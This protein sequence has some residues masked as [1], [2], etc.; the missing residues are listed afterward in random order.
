[1][2]TSVVQSPP[3][4]CICQYFSYCRLCQTCSA[5]EFVVTDTVCYRES[6]E[7]AIDWDLF[8]SW[9]ALQKTYWAHAAWV[10]G[11]CWLLVSLPCWEVHIW[12]RTDICRY[13]YTLASLPLTGDSMIWD[14]PQR[15]KN[16]YSPCLW[17]WRFILVLKNS[18]PLDPVVSYTHSTFPNA[19]SLR[20]CSQM[21]RSP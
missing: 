6:T 21:I 5:A 15:K 9:R 1:V 19:I 4:E 3:V 12:G 16:W 17:T 11:L 8:F 10:A 7:A 2:D 13:V 20:M 18:F 14:I